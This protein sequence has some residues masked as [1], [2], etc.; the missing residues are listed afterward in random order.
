[1]KNI[2]SAVARHYGGADLLA[3]IFSGLD[4][5]GADRNRLRPEDVAPVDEFHIGGREATTHAVAKMSLA[6]GQHVLDIGCGLGGAARYIAAQFGCKVTG[7]DLTP[8]YISVAKTLTELTGLQDKAS[9]EV[10][11][12]L[13]MPFEDEAFDAA[14]TLHVAMNIPRRAALYAGIVYFTNPRG[15]SRFCLDGSER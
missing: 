4:A 11:S 14:I 10:A 6:A 3:R 2:E 15:W 8:E 7:I 9:F 12:A 5:A 1:M 13:A